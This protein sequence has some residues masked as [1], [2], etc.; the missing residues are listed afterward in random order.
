MLMKQKTL[1][2]VLQLERNITTPISHEY[3]NVSK[4]FESEYDLN[5]YSYINCGNIKNTLM[6]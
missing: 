6:S 2:V 4:T 3:S 5:E 1:T